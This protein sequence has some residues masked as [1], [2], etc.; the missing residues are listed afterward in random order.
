MLPSISTP[1]PKFGR[2]QHVLVSH[3]PASTQPRACGP[4]TWRPV[5][6]ASRRGIPSRQRGRRLP[7]GSAR[8]LWDRWGGCGSLYGG[9]GWR[10]ARRG[11]RAT[12][13]ERTATS[14]RT[15][16]PLLVGPLGRAPDALFICAIGS[17]SRLSGSRLS[18]LG[19]DWYYWRSVMR[20]LTWSCG[21][22][23][24]LVLVTVRFVMQRRTCLTGFLVV[25]SRDEGEVRIWILGLLWA[26]WLLFRVHWSLR[27]FWCT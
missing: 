2:R 1:D 5:G 15:R 4:S 18:A 22:C 14:P 8:W 23:I 21:C 10:W 12:T 24:E 27:H 16:P 6:L 13:A 11:G 17:G 7:P 19:A 25:M 20:L 3:T 9:L 26:R